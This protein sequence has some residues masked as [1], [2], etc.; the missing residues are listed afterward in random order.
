M[1]AG[2]IRDGRVAGTYV[3]GILDASGFRGEFLN[4]LRRAKGLRERVRARAGRAVFTSMTVWPT[5]SK[6]IAGWTTFSPLFW[7]KGRYHE[8]T[9]FGYPDPDH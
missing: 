8:R 6:P 7:A 2:S 9:Q 3:H 5:T 1:T 4:R